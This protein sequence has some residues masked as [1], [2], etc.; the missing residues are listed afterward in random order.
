MLNFFSCSCKIFCLFVFGKVDILFI[1]FK[2]KDMYL[3][4]YF[5]EMHFGCDRILKETKNDGLI[6]K[7][8]YQTLVKQTLPSCCCGQQACKTML[9]CLQN[10]LFFHVENPAGTFV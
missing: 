6:Q 1:V 8:L 2:I 10:Q 7:L 4:P 3:R 9:C 5:F